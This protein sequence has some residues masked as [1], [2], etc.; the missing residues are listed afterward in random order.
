MTTTTETETKVHPFQVAGLGLAPFRYVGVVYQDIAYGQAVVGKR[1]MGNPGI[2]MTTKPGGTCAYCGA[3]ILNMF[4]VKSADGKVFHV[5]SDCILKT[6]GADHPIARKVRKATSER[7]KAQRL[8]HK[9]AQVA[10][11][12]ELLQREDAR[13]VL[14]ALPH[15]T[16]FL[17]SKGETLL[18]WA[19][20]VMEVGGMNGRVKVAQAIAAR[21]ATGAAR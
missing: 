11:A 5:G 14:G 3:Y 1:E 13:A 6:Y 8:A 17:A 21:M 9:G 7:A 10:A 2:L 20:Y 12:A 16:P 18:S 15:P 4:N 19:E